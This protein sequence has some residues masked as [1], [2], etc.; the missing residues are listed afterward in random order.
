MA[1]VAK[2]MEGSCVSAVLNG[3]VFDMVNDRHSAYVSVP[4][5]HDP[6]HHIT[7]G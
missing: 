2:Q 3:R 7:V 4:K 5:P 6:H 1:E